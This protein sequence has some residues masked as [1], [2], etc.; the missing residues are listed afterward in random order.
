VLPL[1]A[2]TYVGLSDIM[3]WGELGLTGMAQE[4]V[5]VQDLSRF[6]LDARVRRTTYMMQLATANGTADS[7]FQ[8]A[9]ISDWTEVQ[10]NGIIQN[11]DIAL[12]QVGH[13]RII[14]H[15]GIEIAGVTPADYV[16]ATIVRTLTTQ[17]A[18]FTPVASFGALTTSHLTATPVGLWML[19]QT[20]GLSEV[21]GVIRSVGT[22]VNAIT[23]TS[24]F[25]LSAPRG[26][27]NLYPGV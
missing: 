22:D 4:V 24:I 15:A 10:V 18:V 21:G 23:R 12:P 6:L 27:M 20:L 9:D 11:A 2:N 5:P 1:G 7:V 19:P 26:V 3:N 25:M 17:Q 8:W 13:E 16:S 14:T